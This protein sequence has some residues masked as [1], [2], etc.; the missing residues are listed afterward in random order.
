MKRAPSRRP[1]SIVIATPLLASVLLAEFVD[2]SAGVDDLLFARVERVAVRADFD[3]QVVS[4]R[5][6]RDER[7]PAAAG[8]GGL[9]IFGMDAGFH[10]FERIS[11]PGEKVGQC[12]DAGTLPQD[13]KRRSPVT[14]E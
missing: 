11:A 1:L 9:F 14:G 4:E 6:T 2:A 7:V 3:L 12:S 5:G 13:G 10:G 8:H